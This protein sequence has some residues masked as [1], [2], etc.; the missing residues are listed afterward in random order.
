MKTRVAVSSRL[1]GITATIRGIGEWFTGHLVQNVPE[2]LSVCEYECD[3]PSC[4]IGKWALC[5][6]VRRQP[7]ETC[8]DLD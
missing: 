1:L 3:E 7:D 6:K 8:F 4:H 2:E 5:E